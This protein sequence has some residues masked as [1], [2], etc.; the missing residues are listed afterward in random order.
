M[1]SVLINEIIKQVIIEEI[2]TSLVPIVELI[3][4]D[5][6]I[7]LSQYSMG[8]DIYFPK[9]ESIIRK[10]RNRLIVNEYNGFNQRE[11]AKKYE[12]TCTQ[13]INII[14]NKKEV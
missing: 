12:I 2:P 9:F 7:K 11:L 14:K 4:L 5:N 8:D 1:K 10:T 3:G 13:I 6:V